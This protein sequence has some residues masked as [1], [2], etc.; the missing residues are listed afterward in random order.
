[1]GGA[2]GSVSIKNE[3]GEGRRMLSRRAASA[4]SQRTSSHPL[5]SSAPFWGHPKK[6]DLSAG[7]PGLFGGLHLRSRQREIRLLFSSLRIPRFASRN[8]PPLPFRSRTPA[9]CIS[10]NYIL[11]NYYNYYILIYILIYI[12]YI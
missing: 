7:I 12:S 2:A 1:M 11:N 10:N 8:S 4:P 3:F 5:R 9:K 6:S